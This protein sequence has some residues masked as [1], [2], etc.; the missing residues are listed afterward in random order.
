M[1]GPGRYLTLHAFPRSKPITARHN[2]HAYTGI[3]HAS[4]CA[5]SALV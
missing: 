4:A 3:K 5:E 2:Y 1:G